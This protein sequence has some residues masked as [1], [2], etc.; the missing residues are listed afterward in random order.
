MSRRRIAR[1]VPLSSEAL[2]LSA[3]LDLVSVVRSDSPQTE[4]DLAV[5]VET[6]RG[7][8]P[9]NPQRS[10][11]P[12]RVQLMAQGLLLREHGYRC[13]R[14][15]LYFAGSRTRVT[16]EFTAELEART[17]ELLGQARGAMHA[18]RKLPPPLQDS[19]KCNG[20]SL[21]G[22]CLPDETNAACS[23]RRWRS[24]THAR[25][26]RRRPGRRQSPAGFIR[27]AMTRRR[28]MCRSRAP[29]SAAPS[30]ASP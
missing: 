13:E 5:P 7:R 20:C 9:D 30:S 1:S 21:A 19:P 3:K 26:G 16:I 12:E 23:M 15:M 8:V 24:R 4:G 22:I 11:E 18:A 17:R 25:A 6:K 27:C 29:S 10:W 28:F 14:G 2:G